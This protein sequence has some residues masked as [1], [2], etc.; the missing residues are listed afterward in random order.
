MYVCERTFVLSRR[1]EKDSSASIASA[2]SCENPDISSTNTVNT[3][4]ELLK[5]RITPV[6]STVAC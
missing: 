2:S 6:F 5:V 3:I 1:N 4:E